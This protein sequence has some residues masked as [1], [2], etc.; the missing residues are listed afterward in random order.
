[1]LLII[2]FFAIIYTQNIDVFTHSFEL[3][4]D[5]KR[6]LIG[7]YITQNVVLILTAFAIG[8]VLSLFFGALQSVSAGSEIKHNRKR[9]RELEAQVD[10]LSGNN[11]QLA[12]AGSN[13]EASGSPFSSAN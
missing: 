13:K 12:Q 5:F 6:F 2:V 8:V 4:L 10:E 1:M 9:I 7:P 3:Q 11:N